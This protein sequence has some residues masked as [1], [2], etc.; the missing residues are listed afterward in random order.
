VKV[1]LYARHGIP[2]VWIVDLENGELRI[3]RSPAD[4]RY[5]DEQATAEPGITP[6]AALPGVEIDLSALLAD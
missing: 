6:V 1:P 2:E 3:Y 5:L 4:G